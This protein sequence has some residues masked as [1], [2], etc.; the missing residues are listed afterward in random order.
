[1]KSKKLLWKG[2]G[3][4][5]GICGILWMLLLITI[6]IFPG[7]NDSIG[8]SEYE[9]SGVSSAP[10]WTS[11]YA[12]TM[13]PM[14]MPTPRPATEPAADLKFSFSES[15]DGWGRSMT[16]SSYSNETIGLA[17]GGAKDINNF[18]E[19]IENGYL[20][21]PTDITYEGL[22]YDYYF[23]TGQ[24]E[25]CSKLFCPSYSYAVSEDPFSGEEEYFLAVG[26][27]SGLR[28]SDFKRQK[29]N[30]VVVLDVSGSMDSPFDRYYYDGFGNRRDYDDQE[31]NWDR[32]KMEVAAESIVA[33]MDHLEH[34]DRFGVVLFNGQARLAKPMNLVGETDMEAIEDHILELGAGG[35]TNLSDG[36]ELAQEQYERLFS[37]ERFDRYEYENRI[38]FLTDAM[39]N[40]GDTSER[41]LIG[42]A[43]ENAD[44]NIYTTFIGIGVDFNT[45]LIEYITGIKGANYYSV[46]S[47]REFRNRMDDEFEYM[48]TPLVFDVELELHTRGWEIEG[49]YGSPEADESS[50][51][52]MRINTLFPSAKKGGETKGG[53]VL[54]KMRKTSS[55]NE[56]ILEVSYEDR[57]GENDSVETK[58]D[59][60]R[61]RPEY[62]DNDGIR[63]GVLLSRYADLMINWLIDERSHGGKYDDW[64]DSWEPRVNREIGICIPPTPSTLGQWERQSMKLVVSG[65][66]ADLFEEFEEYFED[67]MYEIDDYDLEQELDVLNDL[68]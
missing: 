37:A 61:E 11:S 44:S 14:E 40:T 36:M 46:H 41:G 22:F 49:I 25:P 15:E 19:N 66:Y 68:C 18:R 55:R 26:L 6:L 17:V 54:L 7:C 3:A 30:L 2:N 8:E 51:K 24:N 35:S 39:P 21:L 45:E 29:L 67:E 48:V 13:V 62:F 63:K 12:P 5:C 50:G 43:E 20:P 59:L 58:I 53:L 47:S 32:T 42:M 33:L 10:E 64:V 34:D 31:R 38:I 65:E 4:E 9:S 56:L 57:Y 52:L 28:E 1:M 16:G 60:Y 27:N 23:D